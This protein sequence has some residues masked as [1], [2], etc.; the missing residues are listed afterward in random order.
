MNAVKHAVRLFLGS[1]LIT[2]CCLTPST[3]S[4]DFEENKSLIAQ[5]NTN[6]YIVERIT[7]TL[8][9]LE[10][11][12]KGKHHRLLLF[13]ASP[14]SIQAEYWR[15]IGHFHSRIIDEA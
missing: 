12:T 7:R 4:P 11:H 14:T 5:G 15:S 6:A 2:A 1:G 10:D 3:P 13:A 9:T 8:A